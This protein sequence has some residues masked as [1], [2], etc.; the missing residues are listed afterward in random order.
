MRALVASELSCWQPYKSASKPRPKGR[1]IRVPVLPVS[2]AGCEHLKV[3]KV[4]EKPPQK[5]KP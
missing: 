4:H 5:N 1:L 3:L 2:F